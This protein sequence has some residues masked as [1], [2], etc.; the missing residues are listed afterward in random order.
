[1]LADGINVSW[2][3]SMEGGD[4]IAFGNT[5]ETPVLEETKDYFVE[6]EEVFVA[7][8]RSVGL[9]SHNGDFHNFIIYFKL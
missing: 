1:M 9:E 7:E 8:S 6:N 5:F 4:P 3:E 2:Y